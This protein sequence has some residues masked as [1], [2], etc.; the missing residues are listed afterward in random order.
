[1]LNNVSFIFYLIYFTCVSLRITVPVLIREIKFYIYGGEII[2]YWSNNLLYT[3]YYMIWLF[4]SF[5][6]LNCA[7]KNLV[8]PF[9]ILCSGTVLLKVLWFTLKIYV[10]S[11]TL[12]SRTLCIQ[13]FSLRHNPQYAYP[14]FPIQL[15]ITESKKHCN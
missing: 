15:W 10:A 3:A 8:H 9:V 11:L 6:I 13:L 7:Y 4:Q 14:F 2:W 5:V 1:M 12:D